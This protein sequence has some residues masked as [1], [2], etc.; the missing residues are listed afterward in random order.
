MAPVGE[1]FRFLAPLRSKLEAP[2]STPNGSDMLKRQSPKPFEVQGT[3]TDYFLH[4]DAHSHNSETR[5]STSV[6]NQI[7][8]S[9]DFATASDFRCY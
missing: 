4:P 9:Q 7:R 8:I 6:V 2:I 3:F 5:I 1:V